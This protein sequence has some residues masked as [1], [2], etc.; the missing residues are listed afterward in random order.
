[1]INVIAGNDFRL[2]VTAKKSVG[3]SV[4][5][6]DLTEVDDL[7]IY[8]TRAGR[9]KMS[10]SYALDDYGRA[11]VYV[12][13]RDVA[14]GV[15]GI[16][17]M[18]VMGGSNLR[19]HKT[20]VL[21]VS[22]HGHGNEGVLLDYEVDIVLSVNVPTTDAYVQAA[23]DAHNED[24]EAHEA[25]QAK[26]ADKVDDVLVDGESVVETDPATGKRT[27]GFRK[28]Q[29]GKVDDVKVNG[30]SV[31][32]ENNEAEI[33]VP[34]KTSE[35]DNDEDFATN[36]EV[37]E[38][39]AAHMVNEVNVSVDNTAPTGQPSAEKTFQDGVLDITFK[40]V[41][42]D[43]GE[44][45]K[46]SDL[47][48]AEKA[49][50]KG[51]P[52]ADFQPIEDVSGLSI[53][54]DLG[55]S[56]EKVMSQNAVSE[57]LGSQALSSGLYEEVGNLSNMSEF[58]AKSI[59]NVG[60]ITT[61]S[62]SGA[63]IKYFEVSSGDIV[64]INILAQSETRIAWGLFPDL[65][66]DTEALQYEN[67]VA[68]DLT[69]GKDYLFHVAS[70]GYFAIYSL[71]AYNVS[72][73]RVAN[74]AYKTFPG[75]IVT[76]IIQGDLGSV[77][78]IASR[79]C[80]DYIDVSSMEKILYTRL[81]SDGV[82]GYVYGMAF[83]DA[84]KT[85][86][87]AEKGLSNAAKIG[88]QLSVVDVPSTAKYAR[89]S[90]WANPVCGEFYMGNAETDA[91]AANIVE[92]SVYDLSPKRIVMRGAGT[93][94]VTSQ[95]IYAKGERVIKLSL[96][97]NNVPLT[98]SGSA[99]AI[100][101]EVD[102][103]DNS[104]NIVETLFQVKNPLKPGKEILFVTPQDIEYFT[105]T[106][107][108]NVGEEY[109]I[110]AT[111]VTD[112]YKKKNCLL[113][114]YRPVARLASYVA[115]LS[116]DILRCV[117]KADGL[118][119]NMCAFKIGSDE[120]LTTI[121]DTPWDSGIIQLANGEND[122][123]DC[124]YMSF[125]KPDDSEILQAEVLENF[126]L[127]IYRRVEY[128]WDLELKKGERRW[129]LYGFNIAN[130]TTSPAL[131][132]DYLQIPKTGMS[133]RMD[134]PKWMKV[135][136]RYGLRA[137][138]AYT[139]FYRTGDICTF[140]EGKGAVY[141]DFVVFGTK[142]CPTINF[143]EDKNISLTILDA[144]DGD[145]VKRNFDTEKWLGGVRD[146][147]EFSNTDNLP[148]LAHVTDIHADSTRFKS[149]CDYADYLGV[150][151]L[152]NTGDNPYWEM[153][154]GASYH[155]EIVASLKSQYAACIGNHD[156]YKGVSLANMYEL[157]IAPF[158][159]RY[160]WH[161]ESGDDVTDTMYYYKDLTGKKLRIIALNL[162]DEWYDATQKAR[163]SQTQM[164][165][166]IATLAS[167][168]A[169]YGVI[170]ISHQAP[171][172]IGTIE[173]ITHWNDSSMD[174]DCASIDSSYMYD[175]SRKDGRL[176]GNPIGKIVDAFIGKTT[177]EDSYN[178]LGT[179]KTTRETVNYSANFSNVAEGV[180]F[181]CHLNGHTHRDWI[182][183]VKDC[184]HNQLNINLCSTNPISQSTGV[185]TATDI[186]R[187]GNGVNQDAF[188]VYTINR[189]D[190]TV[191][192]VRIGSCI[193]KGLQER[194]VTFVSYV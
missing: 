126:D 172:G 139:D 1:M 26:M 141:A 112:N 182:G 20:N 77:S 96:K 149:A 166:F 50:L 154:R 54:H 36:S 69:I 47:T 188:N 2:I 152:I 60:I 25:L 115:P 164:E 191:G 21:T 161:K 80:T 118:R 64:K 98:G 174:V 76:D 92:S 90:M 175:S 140:P 74:K 178:Q 162:Y 58:A 4:G 14:V 146:V 75:G 19:A 193:T 56:E 124:L 108:C 15:Y 86:I 150:D 185:R 184:E 84:S 113:N 94:A 143:Y 147:P 104:G 6:L 35:L 65:N 179:D 48:E 176:I 38:K 29:F 156:T 148:L 127:F 160:G 181:I 32:N 159:E 5:V 9:S 71:N 82:Y 72:V 169:G 155:Q 57:A 41:K 151:L 135:R 13:A 81:A 37:D 33:T 7:R 42:G 39:V 194:R 119:T 133:V 183:Y 27:V 97:D 59:S 192:I 18:G 99:N 79:R 145:V 70:S 180:E 128:D 144:N 87:S 93:T 190:K 187:D 132:S 3:V 109:V 16:E 125:A 189:E 63:K 153:D 28:D 177:I 24:G 12:N 61:S 85:F 49:S 170:I 114:V 110:G 117:R 102:A 45:L 123:T 130:P 186:F 101:F 163:I 106:I 121:Y 95:K 138:E 89:F 43:K 88:Y 17:L 55:N 171:H 142:R 30:E 73:L 103:Y 120:T 105:I 134:I 11:I 173:G 100:I 168:P 34:T 10:Q 158:A 8:L 129:D 23:I 67:Y 116:G 122:G 78:Y 157:Q 31:L 165:W 136:F 66:V 91:I 111:D 137:Y 167:T 62:V 107:R 53:A 52:G 40:N 131:R 22:G 51:R 46:F 68:N 44:K 83:Y